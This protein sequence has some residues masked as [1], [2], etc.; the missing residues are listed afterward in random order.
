MTADISTERVF[1]LPCFEGVRLL[2]HY[3]KMHPELGTTELI[4]LVEN[5]EA[6]GA[7]LDLV[8]SAHLETLVDHDCLMDGAAFYQACVKAVL[9]KHQP[10]WSKTMRS[11][12]AR[13]TRTLDLNDQDV[14]SA[15]GLTDNP[16][17]IEVIRWWDDVSGHARLITD[18]VNM[19]QARRAELL[20]LEHERQ[21]LAKI[22]I[23][24]EP[25]WPG[26][27]DNYAGYDVLS[28]DLGE[29]GLIN[30][31]IEVKST[32]ASPLRFFVSRNEWNKAEEAASAYLFHIW[33]MKQSPAVLYIRT[34][35]EIEPHIP[36]DNEKGKWKIAEIPIV[37]S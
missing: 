25:E 8:A 3:G 12:R 14:F 26:L 27:D 7:S 15:A 6:D 2:R 29:Y 19:E 20:T 30:R 9:V 34:V 21:R 22:G 32:S 13:F 18:Q 5:I 28:Y 31:M 1:S 35:K 16:L 37:S 33:D 10:I 24:K 17:P 36:I 4:A 11:G 23:A